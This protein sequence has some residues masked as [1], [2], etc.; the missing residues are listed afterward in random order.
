[1]GEGLILEGMDFPRDSIKREHLL[2]KG[3]Y[4]KGDCALQYNLDAVASGVI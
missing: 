4:S 3:D 1:M 2:T